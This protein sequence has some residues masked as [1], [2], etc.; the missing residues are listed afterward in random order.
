MP[1]GRDDTLKPAARRWGS[2]RALP[3]LLAVLAAL[4]LAALPLGSAQPVQRLAVAAG[5]PGPG[6][7]VVLYEDPGCAT[8]ELL[9]QGGWFAV[10]DAAWWAQRAASGAVNATL[11]SATSVGSLTNHPL[12]AGAGLASRAQSVAAQAAALA[13]QWAGGQAS[14][15]AWAAGVLGDEDVCLLS[16]AGVTT[17][18]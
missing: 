18:L 9:W 11:P 14:P 13:P 4:G 12:I 5:Y 1:G 3:A 16:L 8:H 15:A 17:G 7:Q 2:V 10:S 6:A